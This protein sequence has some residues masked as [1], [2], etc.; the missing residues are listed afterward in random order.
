MNFSLSAHNCYTTENV[1]KCF[2]YAMQ[3]HYIYIYAQADL[4]SK[5]VKH[6]SCTVTAQSFHA[7]E[8][9]TPAGQNTSFV[10]SGT[11]SG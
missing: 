1:Y 10:W 4:Y 8:M 6:T 5:E 11:V 2:Y 3:C 7:S 9:F